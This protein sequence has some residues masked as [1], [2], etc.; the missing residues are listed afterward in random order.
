MSSKINSLAHLCAAFDADS[1]GEGNRQTGL[2]LLAAMALSIASLA[3]SGSS[4][5]L[6]NGPPI[7]LGCNVLAT[8]PRLSQLVMD[9]IVT[10][11]AQCQSNL[12]SQLYRFVQD[13]N[14]HHGKSPAPNNWSLAENPRPNSGE[15]A[16]SQI[17]GSGVKMGPSGLNW[18]REWGAVLSSPASMQLRDFLESPSFFMATSKASQL[19]KM[20]N[21]AHFGELLVSL[22]LISRS[23]VEEFGRICPALIDGQATRS[24]GGRAM[25]RF[26]V[27]DPAGL[28]KDI[29][30]K[31]NDL[32]AW[33]G[34]LVWLIDEDCGI[35]V[36]S[37]ENLSN[38]VRLDD[39]FG[40]FQVAVTTVIS[41]RMDN[42]DP[43]AIIERWDSP[44]Y[45]DVQRRWVS[46]LAEKEKS[47][48]GISA[49]ARHLLFNMNFGLS[50]LI[51][52]APKPKE[53]VYF[54]Y[55]IENL[56]RLLIDRMAASVN[57]LNSS[58]HSMLRQRQIQKIV[59][60]LAKEALD[61]RSI[62]RLLHIP[63]WRC[64]ELLCEMQAEGVVE[65]IDRKWMRAEGELS[66]QQPAIPALA[67]S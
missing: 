13:Y 67:G 47:L 56:A 21:H 30:T 6:S 37:G 65:Q 17:L 36:P 2:N 1:L 34:R 57:A 7:P 66:L 50:R 25:A 42:W 11:I 59:A 26:L 44:S 19:E 3:R 28:L 58:T 52:C 43:K 22:S 10:E 20:V 46:F 54:L 55:G 14:K 29:L 62:Y 8:S 9:V 18:S 40:R 41:Q 61:T 4:I 12:L 33:L 51:S 63:A 35:P 16:I 32:T 64:E 60:L 49:T 27:T 31:S 38:V 24:R 23:Q 45:V 48:P 53:F 5:I 15:R 39:V